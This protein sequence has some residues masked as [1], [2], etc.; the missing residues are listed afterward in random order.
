MMLDDD[1]GLCDELEKRKK[2][3]FHVVVV[4]WWRKFD[5]EFAVCFL[6][7]KKLKIT[8]RRKND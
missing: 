8:Q 2:N 5:N 4:R 7:K 6:E 1:D 3:N